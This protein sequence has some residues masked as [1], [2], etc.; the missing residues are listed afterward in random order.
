MRDVL[1]RTEPAPLDDLAAG[2]ARPAAREVTAVWSMWALLLTGMFVTYARLDPAELYHVSGGGPAGGLSRVL[3]EVNFPI[4]FVGV[5]VAVLSAD[6]LPRRL[7]TAAIPIGLL[8]GVVAWPG[9]VDQ[10][11]LDARPVNLVPA[12][13]VLGAVGLHVAAMRRAGSGWAPA[14]TGD[15][16]RVVLA[17]VVAVV[18]LPYLAAEAGWYLP[19]LFFV[20][21]PHGA[22]GAVAV[23]HGH[24]HGLDGAL[25]V[26]SA[27]LLSRP[28][29]TGTR[30]RVGAAAFLGLMAGYGTML[31]VQDSWNEQ[32]AGRW[33]DG[34][35]IASPVV[36]G[37][38]PVWAVVVALTVVATALL[39]AEAA[40]DRRATRLRTP[41]AGATPDSR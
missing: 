1:T 23:H 19:D 15:R 25:L 28:L 24:H 21:G 5:A 2:P 16:A 13:G 9:V 4:A 41:G 8:C 31:F 10:A 34:R 39:L 38:R 14:R 17:V 3:V 12:I 7:A 29:V 26:V 18:A 35:T 11:D 22:G 36:P 32:I 20:T 27:L 6:R 33:A 37:L 40:H 30:L